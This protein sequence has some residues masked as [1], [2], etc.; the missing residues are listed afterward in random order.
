[1]NHEIIERIEKLRVC[2]T[3]GEVAA[4]MYR[5]GVRGYPMMPDL[6]IIAIYLRRGNYVP[7]RVTFLTTAGE[8]ILRA[9]IG[10]DEFVDLPKPVDEFAF[11]FDHGRYPELTWDHQPVES[12]AVP[13]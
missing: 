1:M 3:A 11:A 12:E 4:L 8:H 13:A 6:C 10:V 5:E 2:E 7:T 9:Y